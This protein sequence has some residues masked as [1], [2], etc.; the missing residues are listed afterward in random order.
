MGHLYWSCESKELEAL[1]ELLHQL[2]HGSELAGTA[3]GL[4]VIHVSPPDGFILQETARLVFRKRLKS[5]ALV[6]AALPPGKL[7]VATEWWD[8]FVIEKSEIAAIALPAPW[9]RREG[10]YDPL[11]LVIFQVHDAGDRFEGREVGDSDSI[12]EFAAQPIPAEAVR[13]DPE[14][15]YGRFASPDVGGA[16]ALFAAG[17]EAATMRDLGA[18]TVLVGGPEVFGFGVDESK[19]SVVSWRQQSAIA[20][21][22][23]GF[24]L[25]RWRDAVGQ[26]DG[27]S[28]NAFDEGA[29]ANQI[30]KWHESGISFGLAVVL[31]GLVDPPVVIPMGSIYQQPTM[32]SRHQNLAVAQ[33][34]TYVVG[35]GATVPL[36][37]PAWC[38]NRSFS[39][40]YGAMTPTP[41][42][43]TGA[44]GTQ[45]AVWSD[46]GRR[47]R[48][49]L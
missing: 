10:A 31:R 20:V 14:K 21:N 15:Y 35:A 33:A 48:S 11:N 47:Y 32:G 27:F 12:G 1:L 3:N 4:K 49:S 6:T 7:F 44:S 37:L 22:A 46:I 42:V 29:T 17:Q 30:V 28:E 19:K 25:S 34:G 24:S 8:K 23:F 39:P 18:D 45:Q 36:V 41:L 2:G 9:L 26:V 40:P 38:L 16:N 43:A 5:A 13:A